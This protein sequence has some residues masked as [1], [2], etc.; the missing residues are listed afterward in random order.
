MDIKTQL[1]QNTDSLY[2]F[3]KCNHNIIGHSS[4]SKATC[5]PPQEN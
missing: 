3:C 2:D 5:P 4:C 1:F